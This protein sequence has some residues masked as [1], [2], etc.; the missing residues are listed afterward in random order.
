MMV[1]MPAASLIALVMDGVAQSPLAWRM[2]LGSSLTVHDGGACPGAFRAADVV[3]V[4]DENRDAAFLSVLPQE[5]GE[6]D[7][8]PFVVQFGVVGRVNAADRC[9]SVGANRSTANRVGYGVLVLIRFAIRC[10]L[11]GMLPLTSVTVTDAVGE[12]A[13]GRDYLRITGHHD[14]ARVIRHG[15]HDHRRWPR[16]QKTSTVSAVDA[17][18]RVVAMRTIGDYFVGSA[19]VG[20]P[21]V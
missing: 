8:M 18:H 15:D 14:H 3:R 17:G 6:A 16:H 2:R 1:A 4:T 5:D 19:L 7:A 21:G 20:V 13:V 10:R 9:T 11:E 12:T